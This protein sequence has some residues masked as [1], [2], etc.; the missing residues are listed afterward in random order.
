MSLLLVKYVLLASM[1]DKLVF[2]L[3]LSL[4]LGSALAV[5]LGSSA[6]I[7]KG[8]FTVVFAAGG[9]RVISVVGLVLFAVFFIRRSFEGKDI[10]FLLSRPV[11]RL[12]IVFSYGLAFSLLAFMMGIAVGCA[13]YSVAPYLFGKG[14][15]LWTLSI[16]AELII[17][18]NIALFFSMYFSSAATGSMAT[19]G[20][21]VLARMMGQ[22]LGIVDSDLVDSTGLYAMAFQFVSVVMPRL[23]LMGQTSWLL[24]GPDADFG[25]VD[26][27]LQGGLFSVFVLSAASLDFLRRRF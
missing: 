24:Y 5:F 19:L 10:E 25:V 21:Y 8:Q 15:I 1:R 23:D 12:T 16:I 20:V 27:L 13:V 7:E 17:M 9:L 14:Y 18:V 26:I 4:F 6:I 22:L 3:L 2:T 11:G